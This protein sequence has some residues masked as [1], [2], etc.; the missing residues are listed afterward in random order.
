MEDTT[1]NPT[2]QQQWRIQKPNSGYQNN[3]GNQNN[4]RWV[5]KLKQ[6]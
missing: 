6:L 5:Q 1:E 4:Q 2:K 3:Q